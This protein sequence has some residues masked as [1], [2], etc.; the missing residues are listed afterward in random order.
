MIGKL[1]FILGSLTFVDLFDD[2]E[3][4]FPHYWYNSYTSSNEVIWCPDQ[5]QSMY[6][7]LLCG[8]AQREDVVRVGA[9]FSSVLIRAI[10][11]LENLWKE[12]CTYI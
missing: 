7:H 10:T 6:C 8:L 5:K 2:S 4:Q 3:F 9:I 1:K 11:F 12:L